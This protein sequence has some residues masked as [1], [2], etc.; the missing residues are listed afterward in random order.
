MLKD[1]TKKSLNYISKNQLYFSGFLQ[2]FLVAVNTSLIAQQKYSLVFFVGFAISLVWSYN[3]AKIA[4]GG[5]KDR[6]IYALGAATGSLA[7]LAVGDWLG[8][9]SFLI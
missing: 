4:F 5:W 9:F 3:V 6:I 1:K 8:G 7:G 2:I